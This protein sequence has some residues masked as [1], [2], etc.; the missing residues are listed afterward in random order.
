MSGSVVSRWASMLSFAPPPDTPTRRLPPAFALV[1]GDPPVLDVA[2]PAPLSPP[3]AA[4]Q[5]PVPSRTPA[6]MAPRRI[7]RR[8]TVNRPL[9]SSLSPLIRRP[10]LLVVDDPLA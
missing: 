5:P 7:S 3:H 8:V 4:S 9:V 10:S 2:P 1:A 6:A